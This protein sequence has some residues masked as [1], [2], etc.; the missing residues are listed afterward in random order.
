VV[1]TA[2]GPV[3]DSFAPVVGK[4]G[5][6]ITISGEGFN[7]LQTVSISAL[8]QFPGGFFWRLCRALPVQRAP[9]DV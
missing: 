7:A 1:I 3:I 9:A 5:D 8:R 4:P 6:M 2:L